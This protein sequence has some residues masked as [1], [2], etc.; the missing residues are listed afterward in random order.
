VVCIN[1]IQDGLRQDLDGV[2]I[3]TI[4]SQI[5]LPKDIRVD[6][7]RV[8]VGLTLIEDDR[9]SVVL[10]RLSKTQMV[11][12]VLFTIQN[13]FFTSVRPVLKALQRLNAASL[14]LQSSISPSS[15]P[16]SIIPKY[17]QM[18]EGNICL[19][20]RSILR[21]NVSSR[22]KESFRNCVF[23]SPDDLVN[24]LQAHARS[25]LLD[26]TQIVAFVAGMT[27]EV[28]V[29]QGPP[30]CGKTYIGKKLAE[31]LLANIP[32]PAGLYHLE[33]EFNN[34]LLM[35]LP[36]GPIFCITYTNHAL[37]QFLREIMEGPYGVPAGEILRLGS[38]SK[39]PVLQGC[40]LAG[41]KFDAR[42]SREIQDRKYARIEA[43][44]RQANID[45]ELS[46]LRIRLENLYFSTV[47][48]VLH[49]QQAAQLREGPPGRDHDDEYIPVGKK[50]VEITDPV[51]IWLSGV[52]LTPESYLRKGYSIWSMTKEDRRHLAQY[53]ID[54][55]QE[56]AMQRAAAYVDDFAATECSD[57]V[58]GDLQVVRRIASQ[59]RVIGMTTSGAA[60][61]H[62]LVIS[63]D[64]K[65][66]ICEEAG[67]VSEPHLIA[68]LAPGCEQLILI[69]DHKQLRPK[70]SHT[71]SID[72][73]VGF[74]LD[75]SM[76]ERL[77]LKRDRQRTSGDGATGSLIT[78]HNQRR[79]HPEISRLILPLYPELENDIS[80][81]NYPR[82]RGMQERLW[83]Y[84]HDH[85]ESGEGKE[86]DAT[87]K[88]N[89]F[90]ADMVVALVNH[91][92]KQG[93]SPAQLAVLATYSGQ[94]KMIQR[95]LDAG[96]VAVMITEQTMK[97]EFGDNGLEDLEETDKVKMEV[98]K[99]LTECVRLATVDSFQGEEAEVVIIST[100][101][102]NPEGRTGFLKTDNR[103]NVMLSR[104][105]HGMYIFGSS[106]TILLNDRDSLL[107]K[108]VNTLQARGQ[109]GNDLIQIRC[110]R[111]PAK[112]IIVRAPEDFN[113]LSP[114]GGC[115]QPCGSRL[116][117][118]HMCPRCCHENEE[119]RH[120]SITCIQA[121]PIF[122]SG[123]QQPCQKLCGESCRCATPVEIALSCGHMHTIP[124]WKRTQ[125]IE[126]IE[127]TT[128]VQRPATAKCAH[129]GLRITCNTASKLREALN[130][131]T[132]HKDCIGF[133]KILAFCAEPCQGE[134]Q[135]CGHRCKQ[136]C[137]S[138]FLARL[139]T[140]GATQHRGACGQ[141]CD[142]DLFC[143]H[144]CTGLCHGARDCSPCEQK[145]TTRCSHS[146]CSA[147]CRDPCALCVEPCSWGCE[148]IEKC[149]LPCGLPCERP[150]CDEFCQ[151]VLPCGHL[152]PSLCGET[153]PDSEKAC[154]ECAEPKYLDRIVDHI[155]QS[156]LRDFDRDVSG[157]AMTGSTPQY[158]F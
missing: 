51:Q 153:C 127:C 47:E 80:V 37:D 89:A 43:D 148:H 18:I 117:C 55:L 5:R 141:P 97:D 100:V 157:A 83:F 93:F 128:L 90:E 35:Q 113:R 58:A 21:P 7:G 149:D 26:K 10:Q 54:C 147:S 119:D 45:R 48:S 40:S 131:W 34:G 77:A 121:C 11:S 142:R 70:V 126:N 75:L 69:G 116:P 92:V 63:L 15:L 86:E 71:M 14:P 156:T 30:G 129:S 46:S 82:V 59:M 13:H 32:R 68:S 109:L 124:C 25:L 99:T 8:N 150:P 3:G 95:R 74:D 20:L 2:V 1:D 17:M 28:S 33:N 103:V 107:G 88:S 79:M 53:W 104:A 56:R 52:D 44:R 78:L 154:P 130:H 139:S 146:A 112:E 67:E 38:Q 101:R 12:S 72:S 19:D 66:V 24:Q 158:L 115:Q 50:G 42:S 135:Q 65:I 61:N 91:L 118:G 138:C 110:D 29:I 122:C 39:D 114:D 27:Q 152:C 36:A 60:L 120:P 106:K 143:N 76:F 87:S 16:S 9:L 41:R 151:K 102:N 144:R 136:R 94:V 64:P 134:R 137:G 133:E 23:R 98:V 123:C 105:K 111:H 57:Y 62:D 108:A 22:R 140:E 125:S 132:T 155:M 4:S 49:H 84:D 96:D 145:C 73:H 85:P 81:T 31:A 6:V